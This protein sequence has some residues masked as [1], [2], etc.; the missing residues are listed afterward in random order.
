MT[1]E[2]DDNQTNVVAFKARSKTS[3]ARAK[4]R[5]SQGKTLCARGFHKWEIDQRK[6]FDVKLGKLITLRRCARCG[7]Q[8][9]TAD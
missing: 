2:P 3:A 5:Q 8:K 4:K 6:Q 9:T 7:V 1:D